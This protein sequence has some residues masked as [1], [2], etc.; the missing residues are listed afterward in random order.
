MTV[1]QVPQIA[2]FKEKDDLDRFLG[3]LREAGLPE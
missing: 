1:A 3:L 2:P